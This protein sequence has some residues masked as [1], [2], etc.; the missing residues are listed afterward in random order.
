MTWDGWLLWGV[1]GV[2]V[3]AGLIDLL[4]GGK[5]RG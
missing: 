3:V 2:A 1:C 4:T 5:D